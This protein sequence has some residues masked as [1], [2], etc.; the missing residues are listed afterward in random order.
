MTTLTVFFCFSLL[1]CFTFIWVT[2][3]GWPNLTWGSGYEFPSSVTLESKRLSSSG[4]LTYKD[5]ASGLE[6]LLIIPGGVLLLQQ[7]AH[8]VV[9]TQPD[10]GHDHQPWE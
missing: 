3:Y 1:I 10:R 5:E 8:A 7:V 9:L 4:M 6:E 2:E